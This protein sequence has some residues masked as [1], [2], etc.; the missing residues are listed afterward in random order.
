M[1]QPHH[2]AYF[3]Q[4]LVTNIPDV[5]DVYEFL[6]VKVQEDIAYFLRSR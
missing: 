6:G 5:K 4:W 3:L 1:M 2:K